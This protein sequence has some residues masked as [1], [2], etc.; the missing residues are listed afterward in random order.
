MQ[1]Y[2][3]RK[4]NNQVDFRIISKIIEIL[5]KKSIDDDY[6]QI[7]K[8]ERHKIVN[9]EKEIIL[10][11]DSKKNFELWS[12]RDNFENGTYWTILFPEEY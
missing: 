11:Y 12:I 7:F 10:K 3:T 9:D 4:V 1:I 6:L 8:M 5:R 2:T